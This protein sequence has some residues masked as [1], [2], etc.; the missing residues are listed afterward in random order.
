MEPKRLFRSR[1]DRILGGVCGGLGNYLNVDPVLVRV[2]WAILFFAA[3][4][5]LLAYILA[6]IIIPEEVII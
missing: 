3:G 6:W 4:V 1:K 5:G 2:V